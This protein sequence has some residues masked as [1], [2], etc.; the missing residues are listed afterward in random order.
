MNKY[1]IILDMLKNKI[2]FI[3]KRCEYDDNKISTAKD[4][5]FLSIIS[6]IIITRSLKF[7]VKNESN[8]NNFD[9]NHSKDISNKKKSTSTLKTFKEKMIKKSDFIDIT[10][11]DASAYY[12]LTRNKKN[13][14]FSL[15]MNEIYDT[16]CESSST[17]TIQRNNRISL[18]KS[19]L[20]D[21]ESK[22]KKCCESYTLKIVQINNVEVL[23]S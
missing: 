20:C 5:S 3:F 17:K 12:Y 10:E 22:Y 2:L 6:S 8:E 16:L 21:F 13:K 15:T 14:L 1:E 19:C 7:T 4:L 9:M 18:N 23:T 11:I